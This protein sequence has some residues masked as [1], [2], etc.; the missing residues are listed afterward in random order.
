ME[1]VKEHTAKPAATHMRRNSTCSSH[2]SASIDPEVKKNVL[3]MF[4]D[5]ALEQVVRKLLYG[6][7]ELAAAFEI[8]YDKE[9]IERNKVSVR[10][11]NRFIYLNKGATR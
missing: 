8:M 4:D 3:Q 7:I 5:Q 10:A 9:D 11:F 1:T 6:S 2:S